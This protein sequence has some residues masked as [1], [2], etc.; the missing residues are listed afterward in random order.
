MTKIESINQ[1]ISTLYTKEKYSELRALS[2]LFSAVFLRKLELILNEG[3]RN[4]KHFM[5]KYKIGLGWIDKIPLASFTQKT[6]DINEPLI[7]G[8][9][10]LGDFML[11]Y[12]HEQ[13][14]LKNE[15][16]EVQII[17][18]RALIVQAKLG[19]MKNLK[20]PIGKLNKSK[21]NSTSKELALLSNWPVFD[22]YKTSASKDKLLSSLQLKKGE[23]N[24]KFSGYFN[25]NWFC[26]N[27]KYL[28]ACNDTL[29]EVIVNV[30]NGKEGSNFT[31]GSSGTDW[32]KLINTLLGLC[33]DYDFPKSHS[34]G[35]Q[36]RL[37]G[38]IESGIKSIICFFFFFS[39]R[40]VYTKKKFPVL[41]IN[42]ISFEGMQ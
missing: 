5:E 9:V 12:A 15:K 27:P 3:C 16:P 6:F 32:D 40:V 38:D 22:L 39:R 8:K 31:L 26:G 41:T 2:K 36:S 37:V 19:K 18:S 14:F 17:Q 42:R 20:T 33:K 21:S 11:V 30:M 29:G 10:E 28:E 24:A 23:S 7:K 35:N 1:L 4:E 25:Q 34:E 13:R